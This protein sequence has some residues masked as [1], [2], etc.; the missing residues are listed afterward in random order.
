MDDHLFPP[1]VNRISKLID[2]PKDGKRAREFLLQ[3]L[4]RGKVEAEI[5][6]KALLTLLEGRRLGARGRSIHHPPPGFIDMVKKYLVQIVQYS[7]SF[8]NKA[9]ESSRLKW[10]A[11]YLPKKSSFSLINVACH[12]FV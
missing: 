10:P 3:M 6:H 12:R 2:T 8:S 5:P 1:S 4:V 7:I 11:L 9:E